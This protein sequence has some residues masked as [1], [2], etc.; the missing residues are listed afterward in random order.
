MEPNPAEPLEI[1]LEL[2]R[3]FRF[4]CRPDCG[5]CCYTEPRIEATER[6][7]LLQVVPEA[8]F[9]GREPDQFLAARPNG[10][11]CQ[12]LSGNRCRVHAVRPHP[13]REFPLLVHLG[14]RL[15]ATL[16]FACPGV[17]LDLLPNRNGKEEDVANGFDSELASVRARVGPSTAARLATTRRRA[18]RVERTL[19]DAGRWQD[20][21][22]VRT[23]LA[24]RM[25]RPLPEDFPVEDPPGTSDGLE[26]L[27]MF[28]DGRASPVALARTLGGWEL[29][30][31]SPAGGAEP[32][33]VIPAPE[34]PPE[35]DGGAQGLLEGYL[36][37]SLQRDAFLAAVH[38]EALEA[39]EGSVVEW[40]S[41][42]LRELG[43][44]T[45]S[46]AVVRAKLRG[47]GE[48]TLSAR[49]VADGIRA[50]DMDWLDRP[51]WGDRL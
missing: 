39:T 34:R 26:M 46:R 45:L 1:D 47:A 50:T 14:R 49:D 43:A 23:T 5:L 35:L 21:Q 8:Q 24:S 17:D 32:L 18:R 9:V 37:Y 36:R 30:Q 28:F 20:D 38:L 27:P 11:A 22:E 16:V 44:T 15:Q 7:D 29:L 42:A 25:P 3:G 10:G 31:L 41:L 4:R 12:F 13:C 48:G 33:S 6:T 19:R 40:T 2:V 51:T